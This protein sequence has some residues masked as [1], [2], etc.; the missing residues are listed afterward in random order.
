M[1][2]K[3]QIKIDNMPKLNTKL[4]ILLQNRT[5]IYIM[6]VSED[7]RAHHSRESRILHSRKTVEE[8]NYGKG[9]LQVVSSVHY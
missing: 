7:D 9:R 4:I 8:D 6:S 2:K 3:Y 5:L 1:H